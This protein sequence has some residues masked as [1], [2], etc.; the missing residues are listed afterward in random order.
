MRMTF[1]AV[2][3][4]TFTIASVFAADTP[5][6]PKKEE[7]MKKWMTFSTPGA[8]HKVLEN[9]AGKWKY[10]S[11]MWESAEA[12]PQES[13]GTS[14][15]KMIFG[16]RY[17]HMTSK[18]KAMGMPFEG[19]GYIAYDNLREKYETIWFDNMGTGLMKG[20]GSYDEKTQVLKDSGEF[21][22]PI[23]DDK[24]AEYKSEW[25]FVDKNHLMFTMWGPSMDT[26]KEIKMM[27]MKFNRVK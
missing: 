19:I 14:S 21:S 15:M 8:P 5:L 26:H 17:L 27:E 18:G 7:M 23:S 11:K 10:T 2:L 9:M 22:C 4:F 3:V 25:K 1:L 24:E 13:K 20:T 6:D 12:A 16:G